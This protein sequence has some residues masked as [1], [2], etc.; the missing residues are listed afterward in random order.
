MPACSRL[1]AASSIP[2]TSTPPA[3]GTGDTL[4]ACPGAQASLSNRLSPRTMTVV[5]H[6]SLLAHALVWSRLRT[7]AVQCR[8]FRGV[9]LPVGFRGSRRLEL[10]MEQLLPQLFMQ[11]AEK[12]PLDRVK[13]MLQALKLL[14]RVLQRLGPCAARVVPESF[15]RHGR[16]TQESALARLACR[17][18][19]PVPWLP[20]KHTSNPNAPGCT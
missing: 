7:T 20:L 19:C 9:Q 1:V 11:P 17:R 16:R 18:M 5:L 6:G 3:R 13:R 12:L 10:A 4:A 2:S 15:H 8:Q 14:G